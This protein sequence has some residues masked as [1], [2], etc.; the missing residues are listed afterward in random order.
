MQRA[1]T[2]FSGLWVMSV[3][4][5][6]QYNQP[7]PFPSHRPAKRGEEKRSQELG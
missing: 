2:E 1:A 6:L 7:S 3:H 4:L 5:D